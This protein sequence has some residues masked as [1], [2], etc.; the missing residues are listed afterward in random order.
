MKTKS[1]HKIEING[2][3]QWVL[4]KGQKD[5][6][7]IIHVQAGPGLPIIPEAGAMEKML[8]L[9]QNFLVAYWDERSCGKSFSKNTDPK[10]LSFRQITDDLISCT[11]YLLKQYDKQKA[12]LVGYSM[13]ATI[14]LMAAKEESYLFSQL[15][16]TG[17]D[18]DVA[19]A[20]EYTRHLLVTRAKESGKAKWIGQANQLK[21][22]SILESKAF[23]KRAK[24]LTNLG[25][26]HT[27]IS[28]NQLLFGSIKNMIRSKEYKL[29]DIP[30]TIKG[31]EVSQNALLPEFALINLFTQVKKVNVPV[32]F[33]QG[34]KDGIAPFQIA[35]DYFNYLQAPAKSFT[36]FEESAHM[37][38]YEEPMKFATLIKEKLSHII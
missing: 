24:L 28:Y 37:P 4:V 36:S 31:M 21:H 27:K 16:L 26:I 13:G 18:I 17:I 8:Q 38:H 9:E 14:A 25:G 5:A 30:K 3:Q 22:D 7:L 19:K 34:K 20:T 2:T 35:V 15:F 23:Q 29:S 12:I 6:P 10:T 32:H 33:I 1:L 11:K